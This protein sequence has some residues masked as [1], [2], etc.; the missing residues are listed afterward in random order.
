MITDHEKAYLAGFLDGDGCV[1]FQLVRRKDY[2]YGYQV[3]ASIVF[4]QKSTHRKHLEWIKKK[5]HYGYIRN[6]KDGMSKY[7]I[8]GIPPVM[9]IL[10]WL[11]PY[12]KLKSAHAELAERIVKEIPKRNTPTSLLRVGKLVDRYTK[13]N[14]SKKRKN[15][16]RTL[17]DFFE[18]T[19][20]HVSP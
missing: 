1:M 17:E 5:L 16:F 19:T 6:R 3:R 15:T 10:S 4:Y 8:V 9:E 20:N 18:R 14:Y 13:L 7:T 11:K 12:L 2:I